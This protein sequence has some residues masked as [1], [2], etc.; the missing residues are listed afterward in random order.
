MARTRIKICGL[1]DV[2]ALAAAVESGADA[3]GFMLVPES[4]R[5]IEPEAATELMYMLPPFVTPVG[6]VRNLTVDQFCEIEQRFP[7]PIMQLHGTEPEKTVISCGPGIIKAITYNPE[8]IDTD[9]ARWNQLEEVDAI[10]IDGSAGG[11]GVAFDWSALVPKLEHV[12]KPIILAGGLTSENVAEAIR[13]I[14]PYAVDVSSGVESSPGVK[15]PARIEAFCRA[16]ATA[17]AR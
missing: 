2:D 3:V 10:L 7:A 9:L 5:Y 16:V 14:R 11:E 12:E 6:V 4:P 17:D 1:R 8:T 13:T 15:D